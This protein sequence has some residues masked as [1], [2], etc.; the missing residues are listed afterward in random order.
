MEAECNS[1]DFVCGGRFPGRFVLKKNS[2]MTDVLRSIVSLGNIGVMGN[3]NEVASLVKAP[4]G[5]I[6]TQNVILVI[7]LGKITPLGKTIPLG[8]IIPLGNIEMMGDFSE[9][10][11]FVLSKFAPV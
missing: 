11:I 6:Q 8:K 1:C 10:A 7:P 5:N 9:V 4:L 3:F 2:L